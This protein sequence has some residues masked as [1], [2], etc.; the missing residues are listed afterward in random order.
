MPNVE[1]GI[2]E[3]VSTVLMFI[4]ANSSSISLQ[5]AHFPLSNQTV[6]LIYID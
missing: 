6:S 5:L 3:R 1:V 2:E 4:H